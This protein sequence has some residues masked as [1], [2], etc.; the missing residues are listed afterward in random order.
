VDQDGVPF[1]GKGDS[2][3]DIIMTLSLTD[4]QTYLADR[5]SRGFNM[6]IVECIDNQYNYG[7]TVAGKTWGPN[8]NGD[9]PFTAKQGGG[10]YDNAQTQSPD[11]ST[12]NPAYWTYA[13]KVLNLISSDGFLILLYPAW[14]GNPIGDPGSEGY[15]NA[16]NAQT[17]TI[18]QGYGAF[19]AKRYGKGGTNP[20]PNMIWGIGGDNNP[21]NT[22]VNTDIVTGINSVDS[23]HLFFVDG[24]DGS[25]MINAWGRDPWFTV[26][27]IYSDSLAGHPWLYSELRSEYQNTSGL[28]KTYPQFF[29]EGGYEF[30]QSGWTEQFVRG[31]NWQ[32]MLGGCWGYFVGV[33][34][35]WQYSPG[36]Q[37]LLAS[38][39]STCAQV[40]NKFFAARQWQDLVPDWGFTF[41]TN[42]ASYSNGT[43]ASAAVASDGT[44]GAIYVPTSE[45]L[46]VNMASFSKSVTAY[47]VD[48][49]NAAQT[50]VSGSPFANSGSHTFSA[51][52]GNNALGDHDWVLLFE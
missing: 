16:L 51:T 6:L 32:A 40:L 2:S 43:Y 48:P 15:Y 11:F 14:I 31:Q 34:G 33:N 3:W 28:Q 10:A 30:G 44:W 27:G 29:K 26:N 24:L 35:L 46:T 41:L 8:S 17:S 22:A 7:D 45:S 52:P 18:R 37:S 4:A 50:T 1:L 19:L 36:W 42:G 13:D 47:W 9:F 23:S 20:L 12:P 5:A 38:T 25:S 21:S 39:A 49:T